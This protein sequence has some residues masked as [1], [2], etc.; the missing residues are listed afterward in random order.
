MEKK[1]KTLNFSGS[2][3]A[4]DLKIGRYRQHVEL[5]KCCEY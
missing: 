2:F 4:C 5:M 1:V 3:V